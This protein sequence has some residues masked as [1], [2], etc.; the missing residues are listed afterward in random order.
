MVGLYESNHSSCGITLDLTAFA[1]MSRR[2]CCVHGCC[3]VLLVMYVVC[4]LLCSMDLALRQG[5]SAASRRS[6][7]SALK[8]AK[9]SNADESMNHVRVS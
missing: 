7:L 4:M 2:Y 6:A 9:A 5:G 8:A 3:G 1:C